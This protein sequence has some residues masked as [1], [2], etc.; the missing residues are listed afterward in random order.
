[1]SFAT[2][3]RR[4]RIK[5]AS[6]AVLLFLGWLDYVTGY[7]F[8]FFIFYFIPDR[9]REGQRALNTGTTER[10][11]KEKRGSEHGG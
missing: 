8:G 2:G 3:K 6:I 9:R 11:S 7:E 5:I 4:T 1:M 10:K